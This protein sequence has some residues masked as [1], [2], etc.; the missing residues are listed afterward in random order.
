MSEGPHVNEALERLRTV[1]RGTAGVE[2]VDSDVAE[3]DKGPAVRLAYGAER[4][5]A[6]QKK[7]AGVVAHVERTVVREVSELSFRMGSSTED[8]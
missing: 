8:R 4:A 7:L 6:I 3:L 2:L 5:A 1:F